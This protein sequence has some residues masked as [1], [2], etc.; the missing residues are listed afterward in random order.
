MAWDGDTL[1]FRRVGASGHVAVTPEDIDIRVTISFLPSPRHRRIE[2][3]ILA[4]CDEHL[5][6]PGAPDPAQPARPAAS[7]SRST[8]SSRSQGAS[9][10][11]RPK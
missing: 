10:S 3:E 2:R 5:G 11:G 9:S 8:R 6:G 1:R 7:R 4:F